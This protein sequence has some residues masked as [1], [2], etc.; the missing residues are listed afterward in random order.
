MSQQF[1]SP[2]V[3]TSSPA[4]DAATA[5]ARPPAAPAADLYDVLRRPLSTA[6]ADEVM[7]QIRRS[8][9][10][11]GYSAAEWTGGRDTFVLVDKATGRLAGAL[12]VHHLLGRW[13]E[14]AVVF[15]LEEHRGRGLGRRMLHGALGSLRAMDRDLLLFFSSDTM[16]RICAE[17][18]FA[19]SASEA[20]FV[21]G[22]LARAFHLKV[23]YKI[24]WLSNAYRLREMRRKRRAFRCSFEFRVAALTSEGNR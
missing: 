24:Q 1:T 23:V 17:A 4:P 7:E 21:R 22:S 10:I 20:D 18:G 19:V 5:R 2:G 6:E 9:A 16:G 15:V 12:L 11:T 13:S 8:S 14:I 3:T